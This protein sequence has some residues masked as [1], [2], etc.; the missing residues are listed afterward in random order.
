MRV[1]APGRE[2]GALVMLDLLGMFNSGAIGRA[3]RHLLSRQSALVLG[4]YFASSPRRFIIYYFTTL[5]VV[6][7]EEVNKSFRFKERRD[8]VI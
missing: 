5:S 7:D 6:S 2:K 4:A 3:W 1:V 8:I